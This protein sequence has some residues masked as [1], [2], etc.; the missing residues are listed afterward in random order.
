M[1]RIKQVLCFESGYCQLIIEAINSYSTGQ[2]RDVK[3]YRLISVGCIEEIIYLR[4]VR[5]SFPIYYLV[6]GTVSKPCDFELVKELCHKI[7]ASG[8]SYPV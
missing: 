8:F 6:Y 2:T 5:G 3:V 7:F 4:Q 1:H